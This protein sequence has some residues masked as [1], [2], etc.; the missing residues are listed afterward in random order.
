[1]TEAMQEVG[2][3]D[4]VRI[5]AHQLQRE[6]L[7]LSNTERTV[8]QTR[9]ELEKAAAA[10]RKEASQIQDGDLRAQTIEAINDALARQLPIIESLV[11][12]HADY[13]R[14]A[15]FGAKSALRTYID[16]ATNA[17]KPASSIGIDTKGLVVKSEINVSS[18]VT[19]T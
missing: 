3:L 9:A 5:H 16:D 12:A 18:A 17:A 4:L 19:L 6:M 13:Q 1:M 11:R 7:D 2:I 14:S 10:A 8:L 15:E